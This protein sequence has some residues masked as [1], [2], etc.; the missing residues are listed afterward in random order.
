MNTFDAFAIVGMGSL[1]LW[2]GVA[3]DLQVPATSRTLHVSA[4]LRP[5]VPADTAELRLVEVGESVSGLVA[6][7]APGVRPDG[8]VAPDRQRLIATIPPR[9]GAASTRT[10]S[11]ISRG[12]STRQPAEAF[13]FEPLDARSLKLWEGS[14]PVFVYNHGTMSRPGVPADRNRSTYVHPLYGVNGEVLTDDFP[15]DH[16][17]HRGLFWAWPHVRIDGREY[18][19][20]TLKGVEQRFE[21]WLHQQAGGWAAVLG[22]ENGWYIGTRRVMRERI[23]FTV[24]PEGPDGRMI[25]LEGFWIPEDRAV[26]LAGA[27]GK[28]YGGLTLRYAPRRQTVITTPL[29]T[30]TNDLAMT[31]LPWADL[32]ATFDGTAAPQGAAILVAP[33]HPDFPPMWLTRHY[34]VLCLGWPGVEAKTFPPGEVIHCRYRIWVHAGVPGKDV[35][36]GQQEAFVV[37]GAPGRSA[38]AGGGPR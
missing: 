30:G 10:F 31:R 36:A 29:G 9:P 23:W 33:E 13:R 26:A 28:S 38:Q 19:L 5:T 27:E 15:A 22:V 21:Q 6:V 4:E 16:H 3:A 35:L 17:H 20:W 7:P 24:H 18:D 11:V 37:G 2:T 32:S 12:A 1:A 34:G 25:D 14:R 8:T